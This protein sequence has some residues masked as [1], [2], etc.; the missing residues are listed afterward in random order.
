MTTKQTISQSTA[1]VVEPTKA[2]AQLTEYLLSKQKAIANIAPKYLDTER[3][4]RLAL[5]ASS[6]NPKLLQCSQKSWVM[7]LMDCAYLGIEPNPQLGHGYLVPFMNNKAK[8]PQLEVTFQV[9]YKGLAFLACEHG[10]FD[11]IESRIVYA[12]EIADGRFKETPHDPRTPFFHE[13]YY[14][15]DTR[16]EPAGAYA[17]GWK[18]VDKRPRFKFLTIAEIEFFRSRSRAA[19]EGPWVTDYEAMAMKTAVR[20]MLSLAQIK[21][22]NKLGAALEHDS[23]E[24]DELH[25][26]NWLVDDGARAGG[27]QNQLAEDLAQKARTI[28]ASSPSPQRS[29]QPTRDPL[30]EADDQ[31]TRGRREVEIDTAVEQQELGFVP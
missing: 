5:G 8:P 28:N 26:Q 2:Y 18:G 1:L 15:D 29:E 12:Q 10:G 20:R 25:T 19:N 4:I 21:P 7:A 3:M 11:D 9:G 17:V 22:G 23:S 6:R 27:R 31:V 16:G 24:R 13:P 30:R 14:Q